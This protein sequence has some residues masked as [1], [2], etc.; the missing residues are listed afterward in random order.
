MGSMFLSAEEIAS[1]T[2]RKRVHLQREWLIQRGWLFE[3]NAAG[4]PVILR[5]YAESRLSGH[6][7]RPAG[8]VTQQPNFAALRR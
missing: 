3:E 8:P 6:K 1:L 2:G 4:R 5:S 7:A